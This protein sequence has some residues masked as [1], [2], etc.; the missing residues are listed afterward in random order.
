MALDGWNSD[1]TVQPAEPLRF[2][3]LDDIRSLQSKLEKKSHDLFNAE[4][5]QWPLQVTRV[6]QERDPKC[7]GRDITRFQVKR[8]IRDVSEATSWTQVRF[9][10]QSDALMCFP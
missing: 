9:S 10:T 8:E 6:F 3:P 4:T 2:S 5:I 1:S 7:E